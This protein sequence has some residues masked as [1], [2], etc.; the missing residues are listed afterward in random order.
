[1]KILVIGSGGREHAICTKLSESKDKHTIYCAPGNGGTSLV[2]ENVDIDANDIESLVKFASEEKID[3]TVVGPE[4]PLVHGIV[5]EF[6]KNGLLIFGPDKESA[7]LEGS[8]TFT[9][10][11]LV[12][13]N[14]PTAKY[15]VYNDYHQAVEG[16]KSFEYPL[17]IKADGL[18]AGKGVVICESPVEALFTLKDILVEEK[19]GNEGKKIVIEEF[20]EGYEASVFCACSNGKL[21][22]M[23]TAK[24]YKKIYE[25]DKGPNT[26]GVG[27]FSPNYLIDQDV[28]KEIKDKLIGDIEKGLEKDNLLFSGIL[29]IGFMVTKTGPKVLEFNVRFGDPETQVLLPRL[30]S[31]F[32]NL[33]YKAAKGELEKEDVKF[34]ND[35]CMTVI[36]TSGGYPASCKKGYKIEGLDQVDQD[37]IQV[38]HNGTSLTEDGFVT[39][40]GR[41]LSIT[42]KGDTLETC[43][44]TIY[45]EIDKISFTNS[46]FRKDIGRI[47]LN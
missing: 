31:D 9:K 34:S 10:E 7:Q 2:A 44:D 29:F 3:L 40:G 15:E 4:D 17:V 45:K 13:N 43:R 19:F 26:G 25:D 41:V 35:A 22:F 37:K 1:M 20:L 11:F 21:F 47:N 27:C 18:C 23:D 36:M 33:L 46:Y 6:R 8:K 38:I 39:A 42:S 32:A 30:D 14:I 5:D 28:M 12:R 16:I 24:D